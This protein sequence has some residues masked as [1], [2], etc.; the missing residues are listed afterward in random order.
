MK[1][2]FLC[3]GAYL[4]GAIPFG[5]LF[6]KLKGIDPRTAG[7]K[8]IG[9]TN[10]LRTA[11]P[12]PAL[13]TLIFDISKGG[14]VVII[15][16]LLN[17]WPSSGG[18]SNN[19]DNL[20]VWLPGL[21]A[22]LGHNFPVYLGFKGGKGVATSIGTMVA[23]Y[24]PA[25]L[26]VVC[27]WLFV[28]LITRYSSLSALI[29]LGLS[30]LVFILF[31]K[32]GMIF[33]TIAVAILG[34]LRHRDNIKRLI[35]GTEKKI[36]ERVMIILFLIITV[37]LPLHGRECY[38]APTPPT[39]ALLEKPTTTVTYANG[40]LT[41]NSLVL[42]S[43]LYEEALEKGLKFPE[44]VMRYV[45][46]KKDLTATDLEGLLRFETSSPSVYFKLAELYSRKGFEGI[47]KGFPYL[48]EGFKASLKDF[49]WSLNLL[50]LFSGIIIIS[51][52]VSLTIVSLIRLPIDVPLLRHEA[53]ESKLSYLWFVMLI[54]SALAGVPYFTASILV[55]GA[56]HKTSRTFKVF[57]ATW[58]LFLLI[59]PFLIQKEK[60][61]LKILSN[62]YVRAV[63]LVN[64]SRDN[65][66]ILYIPSLSGNS[67]MDS[68]FSFSKALALKR[69]GRISEALEILKGLSE[70]AETLPHHLAYKVFN[71]LG[72]C[73]FLKGNIDE[74]IKMYQ[75][76]LELKK[77]PQSLYNLSQASKEKLDF[78]KGAEYYEEA[79]RLDG[80]LISRFTKISSR[81]PN[82]FLMDITL[83]TS[84]IIKFGLSPAVT[85]PLNTVTPFP[86]VRKSEGVGGEVTVR[87]YELLIPAILIFLL[88]IKLPLKAYRCTRCG[89]VICNVCLKKELWGRM[90][91]DCYEVLVTPEKIDSKTRLQRLLHLQ[92]IKTSKKRLLWIVAPIPGVS[93]IISD[94]L[95]S[96]IFILNLLI[97]SILFYI[98]GKG[99][100]IEN[101]SQYYL[102]FL[103]IGTAILILLIHLF[104]FR[105]ISKTWP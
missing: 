69:E 24:P 35:A 92:E 88:F 99:Y 45:L 49:T 20:T 61:I 26:T 27:I 15:A 60:K 46:N 48:M 29:S 79:I 23:L 42:F 83:D 17:T 7:S 93:Q 63:R 77:T 11:G 91:P 14:L 13:L 19:G 12:I 33:F 68:Y 74:A 98:A 81:S 36:G 28:A 100:T 59:M 71:N 22:I 86:D 31:K 8:N 34:I 70:K 76:S 64:E 53:E 84:E 57:L 1:I 97:L 16:R 21:F 67:E 103:G 4:I 40:T 50:L 73:L 18:A 5:L 30:P 62:P 82:R 38:S 65:S 72:N 104:S 95:G 32:S 9:A 37:A 51:L 58:C 75:K 66:F 56:I 54:V 47:L 55:F 89:K 101:I 90:C 52:I 25:G 39:S 85:S 44:D 102:T 2:L 6:A 105:R 94:R 41:T 10:V 3:V 80:E 43:D 96:G 78:S 87:F